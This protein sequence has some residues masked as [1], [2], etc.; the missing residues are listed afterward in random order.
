MLFGGR[1]KD[2]QASVFFL[3]GELSDMGFI[4]GN[5]DIEAVVLVVDFVDEMVE[6]GCGKNER[7]N[8]VWIFASDNFQVRIYHPP[9]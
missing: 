9:S 8:H 3:D 2:V 1:T 4:I 7:H 5:G 6:H